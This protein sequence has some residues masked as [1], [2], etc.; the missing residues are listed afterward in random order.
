MQWVIL[1]L[2][3]GTTVYVLKKIFSC[4]GAGTRF[5]ELKTIPGEKQNKYKRQFKTKVVG[6]SY[7]NEDGSSRQ[8]AI[9][10]LDLGQ[11]DTGRI[12]SL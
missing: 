4:R 12:A 7:D 1:I 2:L 8:K 5:I 9:K 3:I 11:R 6:V 10:K